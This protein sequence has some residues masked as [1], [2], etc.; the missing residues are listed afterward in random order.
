[1]L[2]LHRMPIDMIELL[3]VNKYGIRPQKLQLVMAGFS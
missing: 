2:R 1:M 3:C